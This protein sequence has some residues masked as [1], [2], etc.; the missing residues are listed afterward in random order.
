MSNDFELPSSFVSKPPASRP[1]KKGPVFPV[2]QSAAPTQS[3]TPPTQPKAQ[4]STSSNTETENITPEAGANPG[5]SPNSEPVYDEKELLAIFDDIIFSGEYRET[6]MVKGR[7]PVEF[8]TRTAEEISEIQRNIDAAGA[9][10]IST[11]ESIRSLMNL[12]YALVSFKG[13]DLGTMK[14][15][16]RIKFVEQ[17]PGPIVGTLLRLLSVFDNKVAQACRDGKENF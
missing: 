16:E 5:S 7:V 2:Q 15:A 9:N 4:V 10:L 17:L 11:V 12:K 13:T 6:V 3:P 14:A 8:R 1:S